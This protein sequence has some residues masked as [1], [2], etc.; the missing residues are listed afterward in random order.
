LPF[1]DLWIKTS[2]MDKSKMEAPEVI[3]S[4]EIYHGRI[5]EI[6]SDR[7]RE[8]G[9]TY[10][11]EYVRHPGSAVIIALHEDKT[12]A[13]VNQYR[14]P[15]VRYLLE[16]P[17]GSRDGNELPEECAA[18][19]LEEELGLKAERFEKLTE[20]FP[21]P[22]FCSEKMWVYLATGLSETTK[23]PEEDEIIET[24]RIP[25]SR[26]LEMIEDGEIEDAKTIIGIMMTAQR[27][28]INSTL[29]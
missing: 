21:S 13:L 7:V 22:G 10:D 27:L 8:G 29:A 16:A 19:E 1:K 23:K 26:A 17:A 4:Q 28:G 20:F 15:A 2:Y 6:M 24:V 5:F 12:V 18:R 9:V 3:S 14:H 11:R 25:L